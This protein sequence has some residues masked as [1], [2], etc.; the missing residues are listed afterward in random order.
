[1]EWVE[2]LFRGDI[3]LLYKEIVEVSSWTAPTYRLARPS[4]RVTQLDADADNYH[5]AVARVCSD[6]KIASIEPCNIESVRDMYIQQVLF[7]GFPSP[8]KTA[9]QRHRLPGDI[10]KTIRSGA[11]HGTSGENCDSIDMSIDL[12]SMN[13]PDINND[14][15]DLFDIIYNNIITSSIQVYFTDT[16]LFYLYNDPDYLTKLRPLD[17]PFSARRIIAMHVAKGISVRFSQHLLPHNFAIGVNGG[18]NS[19]IKIMQ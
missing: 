3:A 8:P 11:K 4:N 12:A 9:A 5:S 7:L 1:M 2:R 16:Y 15:R 17:I 18:M 6:A 13:H 14:T 10:C 19:I